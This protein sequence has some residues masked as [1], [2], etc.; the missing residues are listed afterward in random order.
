MDTPHDLFPLSS[1]DFWYPK[2]QHLDIPKPKTKIILTR[3]DPTEW[4]SF[5]DGAMLSEKDLK[6]LHDTANKMGYP[7]FMKNSYTSGKHNYEDTCYVQN[8]AVLERHL[9]R[10]VEDSALKD[11]PMTSIILREHIELDWLFKAF[12]GLPISPERRYFTDNGKYPVTTHTGLKR[13]LGSVPA[14]TR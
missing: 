3:T 11:Q 13:L 7:L 12:K 4:W 8:E 6:L 10:I 5:L 2:I 1:M 9:Y 14:P